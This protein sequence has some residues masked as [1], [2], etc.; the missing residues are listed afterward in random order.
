MWISVNQFVRKWIHFVKRTVRSIYAWQS[1]LGN[2]LGS[3]LTDFPELL[4]I[5]KYVL[6]DLN[7]KI[8]SK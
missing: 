5:R 3:K 6:P 4:E 1:F 7:K 2:Q 8:V